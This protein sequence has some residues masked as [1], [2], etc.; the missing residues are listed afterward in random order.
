MHT[1]ITKNVENTRIFQILF[2]ICDNDN[3]KDD[4]MNNK[5][6]I[7]PQLII[8]YDFKHLF[9]YRMLY[10][11]MAYYDTDS[12]RVFID[13][14]DIVLRYN[15]NYHSVNNAIKELIDNNIIAKCKHHKNQYTINNK[16]FIDFTND[17]TK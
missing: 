15:S 14:Q 8:K 11:I 2:Y 6:T 4:D 5:C 17:I 10:H 13:K 16:V 7:N 9:T 12:K 1:N 3:N